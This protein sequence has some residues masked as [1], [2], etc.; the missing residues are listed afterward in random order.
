MRVVHPRHLARQLN[1]LPRLQ[2]FGSLSLEMLRAFRLVV[3]TGL[4]AKG[5]S[6]ERALEYMRENYPGGEADMVSGIERYMADPGQALSYKIGQLKIQ[7]IRSRSEA[8]LGKAFAV[9]PDQIWLR[10]I[11]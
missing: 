11:K 8:T 6:R 1:S 10:K 3:D 5:W 9:I 7:E 4:H 2:Y